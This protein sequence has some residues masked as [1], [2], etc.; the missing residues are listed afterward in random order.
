MEPLSNILLIICLCS[1]IVYCKCI[2][3]NSFVKSKKKLPKERKVQSLL[4]LS[5]TGEVKK[6][7]RTYSD[8]TANCTAET[9]YL[10]TARLGGGHKGI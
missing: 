2:A 1:N 10:R 3:S 4:L 8:S 6:R 7:H 9:E 5:D